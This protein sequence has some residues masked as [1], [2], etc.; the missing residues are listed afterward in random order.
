MENKIKEVQEYF[1]RKIVGGKYEVIE[2]GQFQWSIKVDEYNFIL[3][4][5]NGAEFIDVRGFM[6]FKL[7]EA[8]CFRMDSQSKYEK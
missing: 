1:R 2:L 4:V 3:W 8:D 7:S 6:K 5:G